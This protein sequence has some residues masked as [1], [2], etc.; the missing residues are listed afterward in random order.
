MSKRGSN[1][2]TA[3]TSRQRADHHHSKLSTHLEQHRQTIRTLHMQRKR[4]IKREQT[5]EQQLRELH[6]SSAAPTPMML[7]VALPQAPPNDQHRGLG[8]NPTATESENMQENEMPDLSI[9]DL[10]KCA[11][12]VQSLLQH[13]TDLQKSLDHPQ[14]LA[15]H[16]KRHVHKSFVRYHRT[17]GADISNIGN[18]PQQALP[19]FREAIEISSCASE[20]K[21][22]QG[23]LPDCPAI[24]APISV[25][26]YPPILTEDARQMQVDNLDATIKARED[27]VSP[28]IEV[29]S[30]Q[31]WP[32]V[33]FHPPRG[34]RRTDAK[35]SFD[36]AARS[37]HAS[38]T[39]YLPSS[40]LNPN[41]GSTSLP[42]YAPAQFR[43]PA[44]PRPP[45]IYPPSRYYPDHVTHDSSVPLSSTP[46][47]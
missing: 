7:N 10:K 42:R 31:I 8:T 15:T 12:H 35:F 40:V 41:L 4:A 38:A 20:I 30:A 32:P 19:V 13:I 1:A 9:D 29:P 39:T 18:S 34:L 25:Q 11:I 6:L 21:R 37:R 47:A 26:R 36:S 17:F 16:R 44:L 46:P 24:L 43:T 3:S 27:R 45:G 22:D 33:P 2:V 23:L 28:A 5:L 14:S